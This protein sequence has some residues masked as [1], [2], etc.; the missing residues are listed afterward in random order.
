MIRSGSNSG[1]KNKR[2]LRTRI[3]NT[4]FLLLSLSSLR[5]QAE[6]LPMLAEGEGRG[7]KDSSNKGTM[8]VG[9]FHYSFYE[10]V[11][12]L[13]THRLPSVIKVKAVMDLAVAF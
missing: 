8:S 5:V 1:P 12:H 9:F 6:A 4:A 2:I 13:P 11:A 7:G 3:R 10:L